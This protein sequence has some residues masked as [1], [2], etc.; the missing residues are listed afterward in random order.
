MESRDY[1]YP[2]SKVLTIGGLLQNIGAGIIVFL[3]MIAL[4]SCFI[5]I[6]R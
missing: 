3:L 1:D 2:S 6:I 4:F 5:F